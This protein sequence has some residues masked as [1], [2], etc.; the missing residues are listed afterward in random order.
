MYGFVIA[1]YFL[2]SLVVVGVYD[3]YAIYYLPPEETVSHY[4]RAW[5]RDVPAF[6]VAIGF[7]LGH[8]FFPLPHDKIAPPRPPPPTL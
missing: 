5:V 1:C 4:L 2:A 7:V 6:G 8:L 3:L